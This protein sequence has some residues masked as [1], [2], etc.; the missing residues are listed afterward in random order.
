MSGLGEDLPR[1]TANILRR[2]LPV[3][4]V[5]VTLVAATLVLAYLPLGRWN[6]PVSLGIGAAKAVIITVF[7]MN[8]R[9]PDPLLRLAGAASLLWIAFMFTLTFADLL[10]RAPVTQAG[11]VTPRVE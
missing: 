9:R 7:F 4:A 5:L 8:L 6:T 1:T 3:W 2:S 10:T 11:T